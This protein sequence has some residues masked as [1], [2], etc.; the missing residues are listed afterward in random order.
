[1]TSAVCDAKGTLQN[2]APRG[3]PHSARGKPHNSPTRRPVAPATR[4]RRGPDPLR[5]HFGLCEGRPRLQRELCPDF[6]WTSSRV[7]FHWAFGSTVPGDAADRP[8]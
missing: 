1:M 4:R 2:T 8:V 7:R 6:S 5:E 3:L